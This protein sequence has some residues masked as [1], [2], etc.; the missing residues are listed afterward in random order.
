[1][2][3]IT[4]NIF[5]ISDNQRKY[6]SNLFGFDDTKLRTNK[7]YWI[8]SNVSGN[9]TLPGVGG[10]YSNATYAWDNLYFRNGSGVVKG[11]SAARTDGWVTSYI[12]YWDTSSG[13]FKYVC[14]TVPIVCNKNTLSSWEGYFIYSNFDNMTL[15]RQN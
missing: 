3:L 7:G 4:P 12:N 11:I 9:L 14:D 1:M 2:L 15:I 6:T 8:Y 5:R 13:T 10:S